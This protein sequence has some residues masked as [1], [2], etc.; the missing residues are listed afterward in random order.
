MHHKGGKGEEHTMRVV[1][2]HENWISP[3]AAT[4]V[5]TAMTSC[6]ALFHSVPTGQTMSNQT[7]SPSC[8]NYC[9]GMEGMSES[10][11]EARERY[12]WGTIP[13]IEQDEKWASPGRTARAQLV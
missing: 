3:T 13:L 11:N 6:I 9:A 5:P 12:G 1:P 8:G 7:A 4:P 10:D 2:N